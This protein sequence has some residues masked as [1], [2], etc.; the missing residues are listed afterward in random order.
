MKI[1]IAVQSVVMLQFAVP[2]LAATLSGFASLPA[3]TT[4]PGPT[5]GQFA[6]PRH[7]IALPLRNAQPVQ[8]ISSVL[9]HPSNEHGRFLAMSDNG[10][11]SKANS[12]DALLLVHDLTVDF[13]TPAGG[14]GLV[15]VNSTVPLSDPRGLAAGPIVADMPAYPNGS[16]DIPV[17]PRIA[18]NR[19][20]TG[21][22]F[23]IEALQVDPG[24]GFWIGDEFGPFLLRV[25]DAFELVAAP[26]RPPGVM[27][28]HSPDR[29]SEAP[30]LPGSGGFEGLGASADGATL[31][32]MLEKTVAGDPD[33]MLRLY[34]FD[35]A[36]ATFGQKWF[37]PLSP[38]ATA[39]GEIT[40]V[41][42]EVFVVVERDHGQGAE[43]RFKR[44]FAIDLD[45]ATEG[46]VL[47]KF[48]IADLMD[49][50]DPHDLDGDGALRFS[51]PFATIESVVV[52]DERTLMIANDN[53]FPISA[54]RTEGVADNTEFILITL[55]RPITDLAP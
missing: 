50:A 36:S 34:A 11:G 41:A 48:Q 2:A 44:L 19:F 52:L 5:S 4:V 12:A 1:K 18:R 45:E 33:G 43:A 26:V 35:T 40:R 13:R 24:G 16:G 42:G 54:G 31:Y 21:A 20:L 23:D 55:D 10:F 37:Y 8:G 27:S 6:T 46:S 39:I 14:T 49:L 7:G 32:P 15:H 9:A 22:D 17:D 51:F 25:N 38:E 28:P 3:E 29:G 47:R 53:N 30:N